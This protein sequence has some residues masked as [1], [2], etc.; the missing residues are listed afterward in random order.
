MPARPQCLVVIGESGSGKSLVRCAQFLADEFLVQ[1]TGLH[2]SNFPV[3]FDGLAAA[4]GKP[5]EEVRRRVRIIPAGVMKRW[6]DGLESPAVYFESVKEEEGDNSLV[7]AHVAID[8]AHRYLGRHHKP[9]H[10]ATW[11]DWIGHL[12][13]NG[14]TVEFLTQYDTKLHHF[15]RHEA[16]EMLTIR[17]PSRER[18]SVWGCYLYDELQLLSKIWRKKIGVSVVTPG[19]SKGTKGVFEPTGEARIIWWNKRHFACYDSYNLVEREG[20]G[21]G[22]GAEKRRPKEEFERYSW[23]YFLLWFF[24]RNCQPVT[25]RLGGAALL[26]WVFAFGGGT[27]LTAQFQ[28][29]FKSLTSRAGRNL[30][31]RQAALGAG[32]GKAQPNVPQAVVDA[33]PAIEPTLLAEYR[34]RLPSPGRE[35]RGKD[36]PVLD[37][38]PVT[39][40]GIVGDSVIFGDGSQ[41]SVGE[42]IT[43]GIFQSQ[44][45]E[46]VNAKQRQA[47]LSGGLVLRL[48]SP[49][50][51]VR[52]M[53]FG[54]RPGVPASDD[55]LRR[56]PALPLAP[57][58]ADQPGQPAPGLRG[59]GLAPQHLRGSGGIPRG[60]A[61]AGNRGPAADGKFRELPAPRIPRVDRP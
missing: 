40:V 22:A 46:W 1:E 34:D 50:A 28:S 11:S 3:N 58:S 48:G 27:W 54:P 60:P 47:R 35:E 30:I 18:D 36:A 4:S 42:T 31:A 8:E 41:Y 26:M 52:E 25:L 15:A 10:L 56:P 13:H 43:D 17:A 32:A 19:V 23:P 16:G 55:G 53:V 5:V 51:A 14:M 45:V 57:R 12:R 39:V 9:A 49:S 21:D 20:Q 37:L 61:R 7:G 24:G 44:V 29:H 6:A 2:F 59:P 38:G 33:A